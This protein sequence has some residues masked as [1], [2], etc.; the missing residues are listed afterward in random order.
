[1]NNNKNSPWPI[2]PC[3]KESQGIVWILNCPHFSLI[4]ILPDIVG[5][6]SWSF[7]LQHLFLMSL[8][9]ANTGITK[10]GTPAKMKIMLYIQSG[11]W[12]AASVGKS[13][14]GYKW[15]SGSRKIYMPQGYENIILSEGK[16][17]L[18]MHHCIPQ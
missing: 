3:I 7:P 10:Q 14:C 15:K 18:A 2:D 5:T 11:Y 17:T 16:I 8:Q 1:M 13:G 9:M 6:E 4:C 12:R